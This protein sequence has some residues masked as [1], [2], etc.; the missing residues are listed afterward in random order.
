MPN[1]SLSDL[2]TTE[3]GE[4][5]AALL[6]I[7][8]RRVLEQRRKNSLNSGPTCLEV[9]SDLRVSVSQPDCRPESD[10]DDED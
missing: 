9:S 3:R 2:A 8:V 1:R 5:I 6:G 7:G 4:R 10:H